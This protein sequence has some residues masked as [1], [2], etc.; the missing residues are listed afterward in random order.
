M[1][2]RAVE[3]RF[4]VEA[5]FPFQLKR[6]RAYLRV[7]GVGRLTIKKRGSPI[8]VDQLRQQLKPRGSEQRTLILTRHAGKPIVI[9]CSRESGKVAR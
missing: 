8:D 4:A 3:T 7:R 2:D 9:V 1:G 5:W 6:L